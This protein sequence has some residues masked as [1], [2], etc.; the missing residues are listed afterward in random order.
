MEQVQRLTVDFLT[1]APSLSQCPAGTEPEVAFVG[2]S[3]AG[4]S[5]VLNRLTDNRRTAK[6]S[7]TPG[8]TQMINFFTV[9]TGGRLV[10]LPGYGYAKAGRVAQ[11]Q[12]QSAVNEYLSF[13]DQLAGVVL[14]TDIRHAAQPYDAELIDWAGQSEIP[15]HVLLNKADKL[16]RGPQ[17]QALA[18]FRQTYP[19]TIGAQVFS[20]TTGIG[21]GELLSTIYRWLQDPR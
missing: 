19:D 3:N 16:K 13:R 20:A 5:S 15:L 12:W 9:E 18:K 2:R 10:D 7:K 4:K 14:V 8:R 6:V 11:K 17:S 21:V 1:S